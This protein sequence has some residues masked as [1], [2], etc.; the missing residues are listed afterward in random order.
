[1]SPEKPG[2]GYEVS[3]SAQR[4]WVDCAIAGILARYRET[5]HDDDKAAYDS[6]DLDERV[7]RVCYVLGLAGRHKENVTLKS[8]AIAKALIDNV[9]SENPRERYT[10]V[11]DVS[12]NPDFWL[13]VVQ[14]T[15]RY[16]G[17][18]L[19]ETYDVDIT[20]YTLEPLPSAG[21]TIVDTELS[22]FKGYS[23]GREA[24]YAYYAET[25]EPQLAMVRY[26]AM[27]VAD[28]DFAV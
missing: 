23:I 1:M 28:P 5:V 26:Y 19:K 2:T 6:Y 12:K 4:T 22:R 20:E 9:A 7:S 14:S 21:Q 25:P 16:L 18:A 11:L 27:P 10:C 13:D 8:L 17:I 3:D 15:H 24:L